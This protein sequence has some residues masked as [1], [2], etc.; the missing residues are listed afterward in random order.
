MPDNLI[1]NAQGKA[2][3]GIDDFL[4]LIMLF[5]GRR[6][7]HEPVDCTKFNA[8][9]Y[10][11]VK[12]RIERTETVAFEVKAI[13][14]AGMASQKN[15]MHSTPPTLSTASVSTM[16]ANRLHTAPLVSKLVA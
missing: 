7:M 9:R 3:Q 11:W 13:G 15:A 8:S 16:P 2:A 5:P 10:I 4:R 12:K 1:S 14:S 6:T